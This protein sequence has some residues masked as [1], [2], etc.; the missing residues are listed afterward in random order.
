[1]NLGM[2]SYVCT[3]PYP[4][5]NT[6]YNFLAFCYAYTKR[7]LPVFNALSCLVEGKSH[8]FLMYGF[9]LY[10][11]LSNEFF[12]LRPGGAHHEIT[13]CL[14]GVFVGKEYVVDFLSDGHFHM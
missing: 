6:G 8:E 10:I 9:H 11:T 13:Y 14:Q 4:V 1:M 2:G 7:C 12:H 3:F 5:M